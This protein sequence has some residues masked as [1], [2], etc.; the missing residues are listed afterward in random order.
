MGKMEKET[1]QIEKV[2]KRTFNCED[3]KKVLANL[4]LLCGAHVNQDLFDPSSEW[5]TAYNLGKNRVFRHIKSMVDA[6]L[7]KKTEDCEIEPTQQ[8]G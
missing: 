2:F 8:K 6:D 3:G 4:E 7:D 5:R 1:G